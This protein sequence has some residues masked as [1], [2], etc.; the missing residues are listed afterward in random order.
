[1]LAAPV[2]AGLGIASSI[3]GGLLGAFSSMQQGRAQ[4]RMYQYQA[5]VA[6]AN[7]QIA[8]QNADYERRVGDVQAQQS[9]LKTRSEI[10]SAKAIQAGSGLDINSGSAAQVRESMTQI[11]KQNAD[12]IRA[13]TARRAYGYEMKGM[14]Q[15]AQGTLYRSA[16]SNARSAGKIGAISSILGGATSVSSKWLQG[17]SVGLWGDNG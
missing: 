3:G 16:S 2:V 10:G 12:V 9:G 14:E 13:N 7:Q 4:S 5:G 6:S 17:R 1:M 15:E 8:R 11:G